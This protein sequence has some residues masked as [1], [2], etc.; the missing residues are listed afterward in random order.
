MR[1]A[2][3]AAS[4][5]AHVEAI[6]A[7]E[8]ARARVPELPGEVQDR[9]TLG[10]VL[11]LGGSLL[12]LGRFREI[13]ELLSGHE[14]RLNRLADARL[15]GLFHFQAGLVWS[16]MGDNER[17]EAHA[18][19]ALEASRQSGDEATMG[20][21]QYVLA[22]DG[23]WWGR[24]QEVI[25]HGSAAVELLERT[26]DGYWLGLTHCIL[27]LNYAL[28]GR[29]EAAL[30]EETECSEIGLA[31]GGSRLQSY[32]TWATGAIRAFM[33]EAELGIEACRRSLEG[34]PDPFNTADA[35]GFLGYSY[36]EN[37]QPDQGIGHLER[38]IEMFALFR[39]RHFQ[40]LFTAYLAEAL[41]LTGDLERARRVAA[42]GLA[43]AT[44]AKFHFGTALIR[45]QLGRLALADGAIGEASRLLHDARELFVS[46][47][48]QHEVGRTE[49]AL[50][51]LAHAQADDAARRA[52]LAQAHALFA[53][54]GLPRYVE[55]AE[56][57]AAGWGV[58]LTAAR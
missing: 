44:E 55:R 13:L 7:L 53:H 18:R 25:T 24:P 17:S 2:D 20:K 35:L 4:R 43:L 54:L 58:S 21:A 57:L 45:R 1:F 31:M 56:R 16:F 46:I 48:A 38:A 12:F 36:L 26:G 34:S 32:A 22:L 50:A 29:F 49:L 23:V 51:E 33:G 40:C 14:E 5:H 52:H 10:L 28:I 3:K 15:T 6:A 9:L 42:D 27:G 47:E 19:K 37:G 11:R 8:E 41:L 30:A 39:H